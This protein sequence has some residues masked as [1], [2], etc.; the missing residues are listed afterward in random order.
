MEDYI[1]ATDDYNQL[2]MFIGRECFKLIIGFLFLIFPMESTFDLI[3]YLC[4]VMYAI[5]A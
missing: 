3:I 1:A 2:A 5:V 4:H